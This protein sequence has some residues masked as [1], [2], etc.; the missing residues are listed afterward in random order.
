MSSFRLQYFQ[1]FQIPCPTFAPLLSVY[2]MIYEVNVVSTKTQAI[3]VNIK[4]NLEKN[5]LLIDIVLRKLKIMDSFG[6][7]IEKTNMLMFYLHPTID[8][9]IKRISW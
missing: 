5:Y 9:G 4:K 3:L 8:I 6:P 2:T 7:M 1:T